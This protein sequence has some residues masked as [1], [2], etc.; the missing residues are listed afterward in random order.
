MIA[1]RVERV[2]S[3]IA[4][5][6]ISRPALRPGLV[7]A[8]GVVLS[9]PACGSGATGASSSAGGSASAAGGSSGGAGGTGGELASSI[10][11]SSS[12]SG[13]SSGTGGATGCVVGVD[14]V[15]HA[16][17]KAVAGDTVFVRDGVYNELVTFPGSG[18]VGAPITL[19]AYCGEHPVLDATGLGSGTA[20]PA[21]VSLVDRSH[22]V[23]DGFELR[24]LTGT[25]S[26]FPAGIW[27]RGSVC[28]VVIRNNDV[29]HIT[30]P[31]GGGKDTGAHGI[32]VYGEKT[33]PSEDVH[34]EGNLLH[35]L[36]LG[37]SE[38]MVV[39]GNVRKLEVLGNTVHDVNNIA[40]DFIGFEPDVCASCSQADV[41]DVDNVNRARDGLVRGNTAFNMT[42]ATHP[43][44]G[45]VVG[46][47]GA[48]QDLDIDGEP[49]KGHFDI[50]ADER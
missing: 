28:D 3:R 34:L 50:G 37:P 35:D 36:V 9:L 11:A 10:T 43:A 31:G 39:N 32:A 24:N 42:T 21:L 8:F 12:A 48:P 15:S 41:T 44:Y 30:A 22:L 33:T 4:M 25:G 29:H 27:V 16:L 13:S 19:R 47:N 1:R 7:A 6:K 17:A 18:A 14:P 2:R 49:R 26:S 45:G 23:V 38:A 46:A 40:F 20:Q 5:I